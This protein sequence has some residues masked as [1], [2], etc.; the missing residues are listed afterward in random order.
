MR[1]FL[2]LEAGDHRVEADKLVPE[3]RGSLGEVVMES[4][5]KAEEEPCSQIRGA[6]AGIISGFV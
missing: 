2:P 1:E 6:G 5:G 4:C 3:W